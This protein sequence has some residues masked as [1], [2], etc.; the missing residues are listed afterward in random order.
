MG[1]TSCWQ[2]YLLLTEARQRGS[3]A[4]DVCQ[5][6]GGDTECRAE[7]ASHG[8]RVHSHVGDCP[9]CLGFCLLAVEEGYLAFLGASVPAALSEGARQIGSIWWVQQTQAGSM[10]FIPYC[11]FLPSQV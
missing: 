10:G 9:A 4:R 5:G 8:G 1:A 3:P 11:Y 2:R 7:Q 6:G